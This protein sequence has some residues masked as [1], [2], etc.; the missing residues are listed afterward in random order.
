MVVDVVV[1]MILMTFQYHLVVVV[2]VV[3]V[4]MVVVVVVVRFPMTYQGHLN[5]L[6]MKKRKKRKRNCDLSRRSGCPLHQVL[7]VKSSRVQMELIVVKLEVPVVIIPMT[8]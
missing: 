3:M 5:C 2:L 1:L 7:L 8:Y 6:T 4:V